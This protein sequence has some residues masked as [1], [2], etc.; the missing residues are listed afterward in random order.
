MK[1]P[2]GPVVGCR[3]YA[4]FGDAVEILRGEERVH[5]DAAAGAGGPDACWENQVQADSAVFTPLSALAA[6][7]VRSERQV[8]ITHRAPALQMMACV[9]LT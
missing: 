7:L 9:T 3:V 8:H 4:V 2:S 1:P 6:R 5:P